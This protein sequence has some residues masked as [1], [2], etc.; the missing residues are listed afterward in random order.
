M[1]D[2]HLD[3][4]GFAALRLRPCPTW[5]TRRRAGDIH[6]TASKLRSRSPTHLGPRGFIPR[7]ADESERERARFPPQR[8]SCGADF[9][10][11][12]ASELRS[13][14]RALQEAS[15]S[16]HLKRSFSSPPVARATKKGHCAIGCAVA[17]WGKRSW[18]TV[19]GE[20]RQRCE[21]YRYLS[22]VVE[23]VAREVG[24][25]RE[26][27]TLHTSRV[28]C[29]NHACSTANPTCGNVKTRIEI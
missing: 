1:S 5:R 25:K 12:R 7:G 20:C 10:H 11:A 29:I 26:V 24:K 18:L 19:R 17:P 8:A 14:S 9:M 2:S 16:G 13:R 3:C 15:E 28:A 21:E 23:M 22:T 6:T 4:S 27:F